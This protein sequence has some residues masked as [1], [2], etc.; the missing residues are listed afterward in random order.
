[1]S[2][3]A[4][5]VDHAYQL[6]LWILTKVEGFPRSQRPLLGD[7]LVSTSLDLLLL[8][9]RAAYTA[10]KE[11]VLEAANLETNALRFL[12]R[13]AKDRKL[14]SLDSHAFAAGQCDEVGRMVGGW[15]KQVAGRR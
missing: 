11:A 8:L 9:V 6:T 15:R 1:M 4:V 5:V 10:D 12:L 2:Q 13:L 14:L 3:P 7:R